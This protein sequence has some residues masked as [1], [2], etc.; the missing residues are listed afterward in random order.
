LAAALK[1]ELG[2]EVELF[3]GNRDAN[4]RHMTPVGT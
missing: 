3:D 2:V 1:Q 4:V